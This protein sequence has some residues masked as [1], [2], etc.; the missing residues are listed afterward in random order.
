MLQISIVDIS[1]IYASGVRLLVPA[2]QALTFLLCVRAYLVS[3]IFGYV[4]LGIPQ[5]LGLVLT[6]FSFVA[7]P[8]PSASPKFPVG[9]VCY[10]IGLYLLLRREVRIRRLA[11]AGTEQAE[12]VMSLNRP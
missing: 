7:H 9:L 11:S 3:R 6:L 12:Q 5:V 8:T 4:F 10:S 2:L 1:D